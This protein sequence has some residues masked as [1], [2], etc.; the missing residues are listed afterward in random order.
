MMA[1]IS[2]LSN[3]PKKAINDISA[4][5]KTKHTPTIWRA[6]CIYKIII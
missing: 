3:A 5:I 2:P 1:Y 6:F 4:P